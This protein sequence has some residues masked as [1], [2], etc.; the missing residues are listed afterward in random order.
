V[1]AS[2]N[3]K[4]VWI[5]SWYFRDA[6]DEDDRYVYVVSIYSNI[7]GQ[8]LHCYTFTCE[9]H[10]RNLGMSRSQY[11]YKCAYE[12]AVALTRKY[13]IELL[14]EYPLPAKPDWDIS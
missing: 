3:G 4:V 5:E 12:Y 2:L 7:S 14:K 1:A 11:A 8:S 9:T 10:M 6:P 13:G